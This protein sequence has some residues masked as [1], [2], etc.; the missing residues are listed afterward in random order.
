MSQLTFFEKE[1]EKLINLR[2]ALVEYFLDSHTDEFKK[3]EIL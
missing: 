3:E 1:E 2:E